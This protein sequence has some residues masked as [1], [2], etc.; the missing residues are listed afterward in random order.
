MNYDLAWYSTRQVGAY[1]PAVLQTSVFVHGLVYTSNYLR[2]AMDGAT[3]VL[4]SVN[5]YLLTE[6]SSRPVG[7]GAIGLN[8][9]TTVLCAGNVAQANHSLFSPEDRADE[10]SFRFYLRYGALGSLVGSQIALLTTPKDLPAS[11]L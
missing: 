1:L 6:L 9:G 5:G 11:S 2:I 7:D 10:S 8:T 4:L 3:A